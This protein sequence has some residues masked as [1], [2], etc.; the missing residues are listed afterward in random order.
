MRM[1]KQPDEVFKE[2]PKKKRLFLANRLTT[3]LAAD[4]IENIEIILIFKSFAV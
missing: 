3:L 2:I 4:E 1:M